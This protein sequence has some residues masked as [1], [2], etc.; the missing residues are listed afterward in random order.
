MARGRPRKPLELHKFEGTF[1]KDRHGN[2]KNYSLEELPAIGPAPAHLAPQELLI[3]DEL[4]GQQVPGVL[5]QSDRIFVGLA[6][7]LLAQYR[8]NP[9]DFMASK[10]SLLIKML[11]KMGYDPQDRE[12]FLASEPESEKTAADDYFEPLN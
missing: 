7:Q 10:L 9:V 4:V 11:G 3:W 6:V 2:Q 5:R 1:R 12:R 8:N